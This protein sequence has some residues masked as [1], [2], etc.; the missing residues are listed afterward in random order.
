MKRNAE[1]CE[2]S[3]Q[4]DHSSLCHPITAAHSITAVHSIAAVHPES[5]VRRLIKR[6]FIPGFLLWI[7]LL[8]TGS[9]VFAQGDPGPQ[10]TN[11]PQLA[12]LGSA[13]SHLKTPWL[14]ERFS[15]RQ[16]I[17]AWRFFHAAANGPADIYLGNIEVSPSPLP[18]SLNT[19][20]VSVLPPGTDHLRFVYLHSNRSLPPNPGSDFIF[21]APVPPLSPIRSMPLLLST[22]LQLN[23]LIQVCEWQQPGQTPPALV[24]F[25][26]WLDLPQTRITQIR[27]RSAG[28]RITLEFTGEETAANGTVNTRRWEISAEKT[29]AGNFVNLEVSP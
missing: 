21:A 17:I 15:R 13:L 18:P 28:L 11:P 22:T 16:G 29:P 1:S 20:S 3:D 26:E 10:P 19:G 24:E 25:H 23:F 9:S 5:V 8:S 6:G 7:L 2:L 14:E 4:F 12:V 27:A